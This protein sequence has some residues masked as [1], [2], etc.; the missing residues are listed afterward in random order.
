M[1]TYTGGLLFVTQKSDL[2]PHFCC[3]F[4]SQNTIN[5]PP[6]GQKPNELRLLNQ[7]QC[8]IVWLDHN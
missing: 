3:W 6:E 8:P 1:Q 4:S 2:A 5:S 7:L